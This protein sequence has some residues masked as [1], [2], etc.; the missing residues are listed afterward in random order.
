MLCGNRYRDF[1]DPPSQRSAEDTAFSVARWFSKNGSLV[2][3]YMVRRKLK[4]LRF[5]HKRISFAL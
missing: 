2:N 1:G 3:Y 4:S 5:F